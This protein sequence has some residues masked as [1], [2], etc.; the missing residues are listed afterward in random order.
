MA[1]TSP[2]VTDAAERLAGYNR[3]NPTLA[4]EIFE[5]DT[6]YRIADCRFRKITPTWESNFEMFYN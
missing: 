6:V 2:K 1:A 4:G 3:R 5:Y